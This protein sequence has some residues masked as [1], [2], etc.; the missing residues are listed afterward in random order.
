M[1][2]LDLE[3]FV[4]PCVIDKLA[5]VYAKDETYQKLLKADDEIY[6][7]LTEE[8]SDEQA[9]LLEQYFESTVE[10]ASRKEKLTYMQGM[11]DMYNLSMALKDKE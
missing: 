10:S 9:E 8:L 5:E 7:K 2:D 3:E 4:N 1:N 11:K 6:E